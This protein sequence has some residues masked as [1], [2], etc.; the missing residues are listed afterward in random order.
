VEALA[1]ELFRRVDADVRPE[2]RLPRG[3]IELVDRAEREL[4]VALRVDVVERLP[5]DFRRIVDVAAGV[6]D[7]DHLR[8][9]HLAGS[10]DGVHDLPRLPRITLVD[11]DDHQVVEDAF[12]GE[13]H[14]HDVG[15]RLSNERE[16][17][18][19]DGLPHETVLHRRRADDRRHVDRPRTPRHG[20]H[21]EDR[22]IVVQRVEAGVIAEGPFAPRL[23]R[24]Q[25]AFEDELRL[26]RHH[27]VDGLGPDHGNALLPQ[28]TGE[29]ELRNAGGKRRDR[30]EDRRRVAS[31]RGGGFH[32]PALPRVPPRLSRAVLV[33]LP[34]HPGRVPVEELHSVHADV[35]PAGDRIARND[36]RHGD[37]ATRVL[38]PALEDRELFEIDGVSGLDDLLA[39]RILDRLRKDRTE[40]GDLRQGL[41]LS[42][43]PFRRLRVAEEVEPLGPGLVRSDAERFEHALA[44]SEEVDGDREFGSLDVLEEKRGASRLHRAVRDS[45]ISRTGETRSRGSSRD[46]RGAPSRSRNSE[47][48]GRSSRGRRRR[49]AGRPPRGLFGGRPFEGDVRDDLPTTVPRTFRTTPQVAGESAGGSLQA[50]SSEEIAGDRVAGPHSSVVH[51]EGDPARGSDGRHRVDALGS[52]APRSSGR[53]RPRSAGS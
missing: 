10:P 27:H 36:Q 37:E 31:D 52:L 19:L 16:E 40:I 42:Q 53:R 30:R 24:I 11:R 2:A 23:A 26:G 22:E 9:H 32:A 18:P 33:L 48:F 21:V 47:M 15:N 12:D 6:H 28:E 8:E 45:V 43:E 35:A 14:V 7:D 17:E 44:R 4:E 39:G 49:V 50:H 3:V 46:R 20:G 38:R 25:V 29:Q 5:G 34:V 13:R 41:Q 1:R 51:L